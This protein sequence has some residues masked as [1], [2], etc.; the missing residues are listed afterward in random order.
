[1]FKYIFRK[2]KHAFRKKPKT[3]RMLPR[4]NPI[5]SRHSEIDF[6]YG[7]VWLRAWENTD[8]DGRTYFK[9]SI[10]RLVNRHGETDLTNSYTA[11]DLSDVMR[12]IT[13]CHQW[14]RQHPVMKSQ[15]E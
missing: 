11:H 5:R 1:M 10:D 7:N 3:E 4:P 8:R 9:F 13:R 6:L 15:N 14:Y 2:R 12:A